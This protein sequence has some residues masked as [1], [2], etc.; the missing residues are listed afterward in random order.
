MGFAGNWSGFLVDSGCWAS[1][2]TNVS[3]DAVSTDRNMTMDVRYC[4]PTADTKKFAVVQRDWR[5]FNLDR[6][7][8]VR[9]SEI[10]RHAPKRSVFNVSVTGTLNEKTIKVGALSAY[11]IT[12]PR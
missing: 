5:K 1:R 12:T 7:G 6:G 8:N 3:Q 9:A 2:Q 10:V 11:S 4:S